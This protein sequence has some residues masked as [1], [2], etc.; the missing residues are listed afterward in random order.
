VQIDTLVSSGIIISY[1][2]LAAF[3]ALFCVY[4]LNK[5]YVDQKRTIFIFFFLM[6]LALPVI[7]IFITLW[8]VY[9]ISN[10]KNKK[11]EISYKTIRLDEFFTRFPIIRRKLGESA[12]YEMVND[13]NMHPLPIHLNALSAHAESIDKEHFVLIKKMLSS[14]N[15]EVRLFSFSVVD[16]MEQQINEK[17]HQALRI[18]K[19]ENT[20]KVTRAK[21]A[22]SLAL[23]YWELIY[24]ELAD[25][26]LVIYLLEDVE[27]YALEALEV[28]KDDHQIYFL[29][30]RVAFL[31]KNYDKAKNFFLKAIEIGNANH[32]ENIHF[33][34]AYIAEIAY[35]QKNYSEV[36]YIIENTEYFELNDKLKPIQDVWR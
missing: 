16:G 25:E 9:Q 27:R 13:D 32:I 20:D 8:M 31:Q 35:I 33:I 10:T 7:G 12:L 23:L 1:I 6:M 30:G 19:N 29:L 15:D 22:Q 3:I 14:S 24:F 2:F 4:K 36:K 18:C 28:F 26:V 34:Q 17:I 5:N 11:E 21:A